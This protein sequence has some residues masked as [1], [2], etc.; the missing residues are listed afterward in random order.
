LVYWLKTKETLNF[1]IRLEKDR[2][3]EIIENIPDFHAIAEFVLTFRLFW[4]EKEPCSFCGLR[5]CYQ[6]LQIS[7]SIRG[8]YSY[9]FSKYD[10]FLS[11]KVRFQ[12]HGEIEVRR[13][14]DIF[15]YGELAHLDEGKTKIIN[16][17]KTNFGL[18][19]LT[20]G[21]MR[22]AFVFRLAN[23]L[24]I[25][26]YFAGINRKAIEELEKGDVK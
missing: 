26:L 12:V 3:I 24:G 9:A 1:T 17:W 5:K 19:D 8:T 11:S 16:S 13:L 2:D 20:L 23:M 10:R 14:I 4:Q 6:S 18:D 7:E 21:E 25:I 15:L 22:A